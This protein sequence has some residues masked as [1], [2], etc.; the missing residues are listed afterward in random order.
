MKPNPC[1]TCGACCAFYSVTFPEAEITDNQGPVPSGLTVSQTLCQRVMKGTQVA[2]PR[3]IA[4]EGR[5][6]VRVKC[7][8]YDFRPSTCRNFIRSWED[9]IGNSLCDR[10]R[11]IYG[12]LPFS[13]Y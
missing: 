11:Q 10:A 12:L 4:L 1:E 9:G 7:S 5:V 8:I 2:S 13:P 6:G 3:C